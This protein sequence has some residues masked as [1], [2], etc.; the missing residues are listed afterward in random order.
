VVRRPCASLWL[1]AITVARM[2]TK[3]DFM[4]RSFPWTI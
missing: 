2:K 1:T 3:N 4:K